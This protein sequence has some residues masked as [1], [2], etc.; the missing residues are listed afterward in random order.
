MALFN[1]RSESSDGEGRQPVLS[2][3][4]EGREPVFDGVEVIEGYAVL[5]W[6][7]AVGGVGLAHNLRDGNGSPQSVISDLYS[8][9]VERT[10]ERYACVVVAQATTQVTE[11]YVPRLLAC[12]IVGQHAEWSEQYETTWKQLSQVLG[13][14]APYWY[15]TLRDPETIAAWR[16]GTPP[17][18]VPACH[19]TNAT[20]ALAELAA[21]E[22][23]GSP[24]AQLCWGLARKIRRRDHE[25]TTHD[26]EE[27]RTNAE[28]GGDGAHLVLG[29]VPSPLRRAEEEEPSE[30]VRR[31]GWLAITERRDILAHRVAD[32]SQQW[33][34]GH[35]WHTGDF[36]SVQPDTCKTAAEWA[37][38][39]MPAD[40]GQA[41]T[42]LEKLLLD[43]ARDAASDELLHDPITGIPALRRKQRWAKDRPE[44][45]FTLGLERLP[46]LAPLA[47][48]TVSD[49]VTWIRTEDGQLWFAPARVGYGVSWGYGGTG[50]ATLAQL[51][52]RLLDDISAPAVQP[53]EPDAPQG[54]FDLLR[55]T[56]QSGT[57]TYTRA[58]LAAARAA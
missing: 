57:T 26:I 4:T 50:T 43:N 53:R 15:A 54:L 8:R 27:L 56:P 16:P 47:A 5:R 14:P 49:G 21:D 46:T 36:I 55:S 11:P 41:P 3:H 12:D 2:R 33:D 29:A 35:D 22:P 24:A 20:T 44:D 32:L 52:D 37:Q 19:V 42:V 23:D 9:H 34:G 51:L 31:A 25:S 7:T 17:A 39:L 10:S 6:E 45:I 18:V 13:T 38:R 48:V 28:E 1:R 58:Q 40:R 30:M